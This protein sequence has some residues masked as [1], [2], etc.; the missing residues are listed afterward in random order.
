MHST[1]LMLILFFRRTYCVSTVCRFQVDVMLFYSH[2]SW[3]NLTAAQPFLS[4]L[5]FSTESSHCPPGTLEM[6]LWQ[7]RHSPREMFQ[8][9]VAGEENQEV[10]DVP[11]W[12]ALSV[13]SVE[14]QWQTH[15]LKTAGRQQ[16]PRP[17]TSL[18]SALQ[19]NPARKTSC[20]V[21]KP[22]GQKRSFSQKEK[23][24]S[25]AFLQTSSTRP[26][27]FP[28]TTET[29]ST[30][31]TLYILILPASSW[32]HPIKWCVSKV[33][34][35]GAWLTPGTPCSRVTGFCTDYVTSV[36][37]LHTASNLWDVCKYECCICQRVK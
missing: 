16:E 10:V 36:H 29:P 33:Y 28:P 34:L 12:R 3:R 8:I 35:L 17:R 32:Q 19:Y 6:H 37:P 2:G 20:G 4:G 30:T 14:N 23:E 27:Q 31:L 26:T 15:R 7:L 1:L 22:P 13:Y 21:R 24:S 18:C 5:Q 25:D 11:P 9:Y